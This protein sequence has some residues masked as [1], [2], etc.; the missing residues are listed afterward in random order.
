VESDAARLL[1]VDDDPEILELTSEY[2]SQ[3]GFDVH[4][5]DGGE[6][7]GA[8]LAENDV[9]LI[10]LDLMLPGEHGLTIARRLKAEGDV[11]IIIVSAQGDDVD[12]I[13]GLEVGADDY[14]SKPFNPRELLA[15]VRAV[16]RRSRR[17]ADA[18]LRDDDVHFGPFS[19]NLASHQLTRDG[20][21]VSL[22]SG[23][24]D[25]L[26]VLAANPN[27]VLHRDRILD[28]LTGAER[29]PFDRSID[30]RVTRLRGKIERDPSHPT[31]IKTI[32]GKGYMFC[33][34]GNG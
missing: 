6:A 9:D 14:I 23:E 4:C 34:D 16:L 11:P 31:Y 13:V 32:W 8:W 20:E 15:R 24:F 33:P 12:R 3:Q 30:V 18:G 2:L 5:V 25:L 10:I 27:K 26:A 7:M 17:P 28:L 22:T 29:S 1:V 21:P 19:L